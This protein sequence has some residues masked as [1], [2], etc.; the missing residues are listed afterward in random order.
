MQVNLTGILHRGG[1]SHVPPRVNIP[2][3]NQL[4][5]YETSS[6]GL[7]LQNQLPP[8]NGNT[9]SLAGFNEQIVAF[10]IPTN[11]SSVEMLNA[12]NTTPTKD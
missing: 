9:T 4:T 10:N 6:S 1:T 12:H 3:I 7:L 8:F 2:R 11:P 5:S